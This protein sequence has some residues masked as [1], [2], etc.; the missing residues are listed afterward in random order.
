MMFTTSY[1]YQLERRTNEDL[2]HSSYEKATQYYVT[3]ARESALAFGVWREE[4]AG[5]AAP[6]IQAGLQWLGK[7]FGKVCDRVPVSN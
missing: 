6:A 4:P 3:S 2:K 7:E 5:T 1:V